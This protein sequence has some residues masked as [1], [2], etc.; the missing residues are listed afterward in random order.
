[1][2]ASS[3]AYHAANRSLSERAVLG[4]ALLVLA[5][6]DIV[7]T[8]LGLAVGLSEANPAMAL[9]MRPAGV[10]TAYAVKLL[11]EAGIV[12]LCLTWVYHRYRRF[13]GALWPLRL[14]AALQLA[15]VCSN[16]LSLVCR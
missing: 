13:G 1:M 6:A 12:A 15:V 11:I 4:A 3:R 5:L 10:G 14:V 7:T 2:S 16:T 9:L 8:H